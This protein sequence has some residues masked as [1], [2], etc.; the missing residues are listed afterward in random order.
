[1]TKPPRFSIA[2]LMRMYR[3]RA[4]KQLSQNFLLD[5]RVA[6]RFVRTMGPLDGCRVIEVGPGPGSLT[7]AVVEGAGIGGSPEHVTVVEKDSRFIPFLESLAESAPC[8]MEVVHGDILSFDYRQAAGSNLDT[9][10][11]IVGNLPFS[12]ATPL[13]FQY[14]RMCCD[15]TGP[16]EHTS[17]ALALCFQKEVALRIV[18]PPGGKYRSRISVMAQHCCNVDV[19]YELPR[20]VFV[21]APKVDAAVVR[22]VPRSDPLAV[23]YAE[24]DSI[25]NTLFKARRKTVRNNLL[26]RAD[27]TAHDVDGVLEAA[28]IDPSIRP[29]QLEL[30]AIQRLHA[31][32]CDASLLH[33]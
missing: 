8:S 29:Q 28:D 17:V 12:I 7:R 4:R 5:E 33:L 11:R 20:T 1:M 19:A 9:P 14:L 21:P 13:L 16:F 27:L 30:E 26:T 23:P 2:D 32:L 25:V 22:L 24:L 15:K 3:V 18:A 10:L 6:E 31:S